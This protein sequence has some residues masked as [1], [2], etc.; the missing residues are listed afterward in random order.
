[1]RSARD[2]R[3]ME[4]LASP[5]WAETLV[6]VGNGIEKCNACFSALGILFRGTGPH[7]PGLLFFM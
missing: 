2:A 7:P 1:M 5:E 6:N 3:Q 4:E